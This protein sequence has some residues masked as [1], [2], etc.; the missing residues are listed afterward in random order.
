MRSRYSAY[1]VAD[2]A[3]LQ[4]THH[5]STR[6]SQEYDL[7]EQSLNWVYL[8][9]LSSSRGSTQDQQGEVE[10]IAWY[11]DPDNQLHPLH[12][13]SRF[14]REQGQWLYLDGITP[15][16]IQRRQPDLGR[17]SPCWC[18]SGHKFKR[19]HGGKGA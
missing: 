12:E 1:C 5:P 7:P 3:Y 19:C 10:F 18:G 2:A 16:S 11:L 15:P 4:A 13:R 17:N 8:E 9:I 6:A 14:V